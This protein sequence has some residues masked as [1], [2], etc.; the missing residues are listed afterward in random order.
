[1]HTRRRTRL[2]IGAAV[3]LLLAVALTGC[4]SLSFNSFIEGDQLASR[5]AESVAAE[6][7]SHTDNT[8]ETTIEEMVV[9]WVPDHPTWAGSGGLATVDALTWS[10][11]IGPESDA[12]IDL[13]IHVEVEASGPSS[14]FG[15][16]SNTAGEAT[17]CFRL[18]WPPYEEATRSEI[19]CP[20]A[21]APPR[22]ELPA[23]PALTEDDTARV[24][25]ILTN[26]SE[27]NAIEAALREAFADGYYS[28]EAVS[29]DGEIVVAVGIPAERECILV[30][31]DHAGELSYP[32]YRRISLEPGEM[33]CSTAL[34][35]DPPF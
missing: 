34:Y 13:R 14:M 7:G 25:Q 31:R 5:A 29:W 15:G 19:A 32:P 23:S 16:R 20:D 3:P 18:A 21:A 10:G 4:G 24:A 8:G 28:L 35:T 22:P 27:L 1:M 26:A 2:L 11:Q 9:H 33:G 17:V 12:T 6:I 30:V